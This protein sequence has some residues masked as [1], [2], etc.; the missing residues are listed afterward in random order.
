[1]HLALPIKAEFDGISS[2][3]ML[4]L[5]DKKCLIQYMRGKFLVLTLVIATLISPFN[6]LTTISPLDKKSY[7][8]TTNTEMQL[9]IDISH[10]ITLYQNFTFNGTLSDDKFPNQLYFEILLEGELMYQESL[11]ENTIMNNHDQITGIKSWD[12]YANISN[13]GITCS[14][15]LSMIAIDDYQQLTKVDTLIF[16]Q[17][18][19]TNQH[20]Q[21]LS[22]QTNIIINSP[23]SNIN[24]RGNLNVSGFTISQDGTHT[25]VEWAIIKTNQANHFCSRGYLSNH[26][27]VDDWNDYSIS[28]NSNH[29]TAQIDTISLDDGWWLIAAR[30]NSDSMN[31][32]PISCTT[33]ALH[34]KKPI[35]HLSGTSELNESEIARFDASNSDDPFWGKDGLRFTFIIKKEGDSSP[36]QINDLGTNRSWN[37]Y[38]NYSGIYDIMV[39]VTDS[40]GLSNSTNMTLVVNNIAPIAIASIEGII[41]TDE[42]VIR[43]P[44]SDF[45]EIDASQSIDT[46]NDRN[47]LSFIW[48]IDGNPV[49]LGEKQILR[50]ELLKDTDKQHLLTLSVTDDDG[51]SDHTEVFIG[52]ENTK[53]DPLMVETKSFTEKIIHSVG[54]ELNMMLIFMFILVSISFITLTI[55]KSDKSSDIPK[56][57]SRKNNSNDKDEDKSHFIDEEMD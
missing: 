43:L 5:K 23:E 44:Y 37:W 40:S 8:D 51:H 57:V 6:S 55:T 39:L 1:M 13:I 17:N 4:G 33:V 52:I 16:L 47:G 9:N 25:M 45:W 2:Q 28:R 29:F 15:L 24:W 41:F 54:G 36:P 26:F 27:I 18:N 53:S 3:L 12:F 46:E 38:A 42:N 32:S 35:A 50:L 21:D 20:I 7:S 11:I 10:G 49:S 22:K 30:S 56:W 34:N 19:N 48:F 31:Y 14:C